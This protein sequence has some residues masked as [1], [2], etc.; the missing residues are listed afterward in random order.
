[1]EYTLGALA[2]IADRVPGCEVAYLLGTDVAAAAAA[3][4]G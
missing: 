3:L 4:E 1:V 2:D